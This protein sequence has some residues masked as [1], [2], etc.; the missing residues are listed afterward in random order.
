M[1]TVTETWQTWQAARGVGWWWWWAGV[2]RCA[3][4][5]ARP[6]AMPAC[7]APRAGGCWCCTCPSAA[8]C[9]AGSAPQ[10]WSGLMAMQVRGG[11]AVPGL[12]VGSRAAG[13]LTCSSCHAGGW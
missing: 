10:S 2:Q 13:L 9:G 5:T 6:L 7:S 3:L 4:P 12:E 11:G 1:Q 8:G